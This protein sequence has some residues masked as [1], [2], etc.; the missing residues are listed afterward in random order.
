MIE[1]NSNWP[2]YRVAGAWFIYL[3]KFLLGRPHFVC[4]SVLFGVGRVVQFSVGSL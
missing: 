2:V 3:T 4:V 1:L